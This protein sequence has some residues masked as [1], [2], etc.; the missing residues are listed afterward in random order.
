MHY[1]IA[2]LTKTKPRIVGMIAKLAKNDQ[3]FID[4]QYQKENS[5]LAK[6]KAI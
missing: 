5:K 4:S 2:N 1:Q 6:K 3:N